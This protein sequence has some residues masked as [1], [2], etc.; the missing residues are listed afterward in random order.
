M[1]LRMSSKRIVFIGCVLLLAVW[2]RVANAQSIQMNQSGVNLVAPFSVSQSSG[3]GGHSIT[4]DPA[5][6]AIISLYDENVGNEVY[7]AANNDAD[8]PEFGFNSEELRIVGSSVLATNTTWRLPNI[9]LDR[10]SGTNTFRGKTLIVY[11]AP[12]G[13]LSMG[14]FTNAPPQSP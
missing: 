8:T 11:V 2:V 7:L 14:S 12:Q 10:Q 6:R 13:D 1:G 9:T 3:G 5:N 4:L